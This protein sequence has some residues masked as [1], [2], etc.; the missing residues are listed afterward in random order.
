MPCW[1]LFDQQESSYR[2]EVLPPDVTARVAV[3]AGVRQG[4]DR[5]IGS[6]GGFV[7]MDGFGASAPYQELYQHFG[8]TPE[9][10]VAAAKAQLK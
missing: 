5:Y 8:I 9:R 6:N 2:D 1:E 3:E 4:W 7:G 10:I